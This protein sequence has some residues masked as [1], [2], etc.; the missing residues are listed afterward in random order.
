MD[1]KSKCKEL[2]KEADSLFEIVS[3]FQMEWGECKMT[4][5]SSGRSRG[6]S[7]S[8]SKLDSFLRPQRNIQEDRKFMELIHRLWTQK[9]MFQKT[10]QELCYQLKMLNLKHFSLQRKGLDLL[11]EVCFIQW[12][13]I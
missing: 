3:E 2:Q 7:V 8:P 11:E 9:D 6:S 13:L 5:K 4:L 10:T 1:E 12:T